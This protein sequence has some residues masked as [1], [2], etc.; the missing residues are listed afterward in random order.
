MPNPTVF[1]SEYVINTNV[2]N[3]D[4]RDVA[5]AAFRNGGFAVGWVSNDTFAGDDD[6][7]FS[8]RDGAGNP[9]N[10][11]DDAFLA[12]NPALDELEVD[13]CGL[14]DGRIA[15]VWTEVSTA[16]EG[17]VFAM[18]RNADGSLSRNRFPITAIGGSNSDQARP[19]VIS[20]DDGGFMVSWSDF[21][22]A[23]DRIRI[24]VVDSLGNVSA[25]TTVS[26]IAPETDPDSFSQLTRLANGKVVVSWSATGFEGRSQQKF[27]I[28]SETGVLLKAET[29]VNPED[30]EQEIING[31]AVVALADGNFVEIFKRNEAVQVRGQL[32]DSDGAAIGEEFFISSRSGRDVAASP[33]QDGRFMVVYNNNLSGDSGAIL[34]RVM[35]A[36][37]TFDEDEFVIARAIGDQTRPD[38]ATLADGRV[39]VSWQSTQSGSEDVF[40]E[41][42]DPR[43]TGLDT[44]A[45]ALADDWVGTDFDDRVD[46]GIGDDKF[47]GL[48]GNDVI[49]GGLGADTLKG[50]LGADTLIGGAGA[51]S[52]D[53]GDGNDLADYT[54]AL[55]SVRAALDAS[56]A[57]A[58]DAA[59]DTF[60]SIENLK[61]ANIAGGVDRLTGNG[62]NNTILGNN[63][64]DIINGRGGLDKLFGGLGADQLRGELGND[65]FVYNALAEGG[66]ILLDFTS[67][68]AGN[69][70][71]FKFKGASFGGLAAGALAANQFEANLAGNAT[72]A[73][74]RFVYDTDNEVLTFDSNGSATGGATTIATLQNGAVL[75]IG[76]IA[77]F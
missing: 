30:G 40:A 4:Q 43:Q 36:D 42:Y 41:I 65:E 1:R 9:T 66:D 51:D 49:V 37:G 75:A 47:L 55:V 46:L 7:R 58:G 61:G 68:A 34:G 33:L 26:V 57:G 74:T 21:E 3:N 24:A 20:L 12:G 6:V 35:R 39:V 23:P 72:L 19:S 13:V 8:V 29:D 2:S 69:N 54:A 70:D 38:I 52:F 15:Y 32:F 59:G 50:G 28:V 45:S 44:A 56:A 48:G 77:I 73:T 14:S 71:V 10:N 76:D 60:V 11:F 22:T 64:N 25:P 17:D 31:N 16:G 18:V 53:G 62:A 5:L 67:N 63:G 27:A